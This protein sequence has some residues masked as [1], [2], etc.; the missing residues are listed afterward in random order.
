MLPSCMGFKLDPRALQT[1]FILARWIGST[2]D[3]HIV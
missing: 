2:I 1:V 3:V